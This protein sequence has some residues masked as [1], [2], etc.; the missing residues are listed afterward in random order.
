MKKARRVRA[1]CFSCRISPVTAVRAPLISERFADIQILYTSYC[2]SEFILIGWRSYSYSVS[3]TLPKDGFK[4]ALR[5]RAFFSP[6]FYCHEKARDR[7]RCGLF[8]TMKQGGIYR[9]FATFAGC[10]RLRLA[11]SASAA[12]PINAIEPGSGTRPNWSGVVCPN[13]WLSVS[14][15]LAELE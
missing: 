7:N 5:E 9:R 12:I 10:K 14:N 2:K 4:P 8:P 11:N 1:F 15:A 6:F 13:V 3:S